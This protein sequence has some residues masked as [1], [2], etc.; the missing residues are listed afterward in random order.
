[1]KRLLIIDDEPKIVEILDDFFS[2]NDFEVINAANGKEALELLKDEATPDLIILDDKMP[3]MGGVSFLEK[4]EGHTNKVPVIVLSGS[5]NADQIKVF[6]K[7]KYEHILIKPI[8]LSELLSVVEEIM[9]S[10]EKKKKK[11]SESF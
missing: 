1:M 6:K 9:P 4:M 5:I 3:V 7:M 10:G 11:H 2:M 8:R